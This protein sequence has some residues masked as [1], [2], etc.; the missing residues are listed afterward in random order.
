[1]KL[2]ILENLQLTKIPSRVELALY[3]IQTEFKSRKLTDKLEQIGLDASHYSFDFGS[4]IL[5]L[6]GFRIRTDELYDWYNRLLE[7][8][9]SVLDQAGDKE[10]IHEYAFNFYLDL[11]VE[12][13]LREK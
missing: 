3:L 8:Y 1:M 12:K 5:N 7:R 13:R 2:N 10:A 9:L 4:L 6:T 11:E